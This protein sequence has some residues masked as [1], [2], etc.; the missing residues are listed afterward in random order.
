[1][2]AP[3]AS[4][5]RKQRALLFLSFSPDLL[6]AFPGSGPTQTFPA[7]PPPTAEARERSALAPVTFPYNCACQ[8]SAP[9]APSP[10]NL[11][12][13]LAAAEEQFSISLA[14]WAVGWGG[15]TPKP[16]TSFRV[17]HM[18]EKQKASFSPS[19]LILVLRSWPCRHCTARSTSSCSYHS[20]HGIHARLSA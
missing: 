8:T 10:S 20:S 4:R 11:S 12:L 18:G 1:M 19:S 5:C 2:H 14:N 13:Q 7:P 16:S 9:Y 3:P 17:Q 6:A 15:F